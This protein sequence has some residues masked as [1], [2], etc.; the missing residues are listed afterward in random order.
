MSDTTTDDAHGSY[1]WSRSGDNDSDDPSRSDFD[2]DYEEMSY[3]P[4]EDDRKLSGGDT[5]QDHYSD[6]TPMNYSHDHSTPDE[7]DQGAQ[8]DD[9]KKTYTS[10]T[11]PALGALA[12]QAI[13]GTWRLR[14]SDNEG[15]DVGKLNR[16]K[17]SLQS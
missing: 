9:I 16:W 15:A 17:L 6:T 2:D 3:R 10:A 4:A 13:A 1:L 12:G 14:L 11:T 8:G 7:Y 5:S